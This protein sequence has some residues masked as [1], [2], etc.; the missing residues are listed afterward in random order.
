[1][2]MQPDFDNDLHEALE[3]A[4]RS[5]VVCVIMPF[6]NQCLVLDARYTADDPPTLNVSPPLGSAERRLRQVNQQ[7]PNLKYTRELTVI[8]WPG[9]VASLVNSSVWEVVVRRM[10]A[11]GF[12]NAD[13]ACASALSELRKWERQAMVTMV[14]GQGPYHTLWSRTGAR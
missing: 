4:E 7:R 14:S 1:M 12:S 8:P 13:E 10:K 11:P 9:S 5:E 3:H 2:S 6:V